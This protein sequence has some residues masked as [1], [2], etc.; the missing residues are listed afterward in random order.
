MD[1]I[2]I[3]GESGSGKTYASLHMSELGYNLIVSYT[4]RPMREGETNG[5]EHWF[6]DSSLIPD[7][8]MMM[9]YTKF[10]DYEYWTT[11]WQFEDIVPNIYVI[12]EKG[13]EFLKENSHLYSNIITIKIKRSNKEGIDNVRLER[14]KDRNEIPDSQF[15]YIIENNGTY[16]Q[17][18]NRIN[19]VVEQINERLNYGK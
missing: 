2:A 9:A 10:G 18:E 4:T 1:I 15:D 16:Q 8:E 12:D 11:K 13:L 14:D 19:E 17:F 3:I 5:I 6:V 7:K